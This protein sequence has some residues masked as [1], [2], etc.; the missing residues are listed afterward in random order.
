MLDRKKIHNSAILKPQLYKCI[1]VENTGKHAYAPMRNGGKQ[2]IA[3]GN[4]KIVKRYN[5]G[6]LYGHQPN[7]GYT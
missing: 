2:C 6:Q 5:N 1:E 3:C 4:I 7:R